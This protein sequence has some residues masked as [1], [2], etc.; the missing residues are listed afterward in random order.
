MK[1]EI[2]YPE[3]SI[4]ILTKF[5]LEN[6]ESID[7]HLTSHNGRIEMSSDRIFIVLS[8]NVRI[9]HRKTSRTLGVFARKIII[10]IVEK[11]Y[12]IDSIEYIASNEC[13]ILSVNSDLFYTE[14]GNNNLLIELNTVTSYFIVRLIERFNNLMTSNAYETVKSLIERYELSQN[15]PISPKESLIS[16]ILC[17][18]T[19]SRSIVMKILSDLRKGKYIHIDNEGHLTIL[20]RLPSGY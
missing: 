14:I 11:N 16:F 3:K 8:G 1:N 5:A 20:S 6:Q 9:I 13:T 18:T 2:E 17:R 19:L 12:S 7:G 10:G 15:L 4:T